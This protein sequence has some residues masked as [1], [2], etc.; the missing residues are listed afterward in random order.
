M[1]EDP[2]VVVAE[3]LMD[4]AWVSLDG[5]SIALLAFEN[6][7][8]GQ[9]IGTCFDPFR[10]GEGGS[11]TRTLAQPIRLLV[12]ERDAELARQIAADLGLDEQLRRG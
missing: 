1:P 3:H 2:W 7:L 11:Y 12:K 5:E 10:P 4:T 8:A 9:G 6:E